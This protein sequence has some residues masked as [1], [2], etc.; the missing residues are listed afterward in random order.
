MV[1]I[2]KGSN[3]DLSMSKNY[4]GIALSSI[5]SKIFDNCIIS[6][7]CLALNSDDLQFAYKSGSS[8]T[9]CVS[10]LCET[11]DYYVHNESDVY[12]CS[13]D[14]SKAFDR[15]NILLL[16][17]KLRKRNFCPLF[18]RYLINSYCNQMMM[19]RWNGSLSSKFDVIN[20][21]KQGGALSPLLFFFFGMEEFYSYKEKTLQKRQSRETKY[22]TTTKKNIDITMYNYKLYTIARLVPNKSIQAVQLIY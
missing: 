16:F 1:P 22:N 3:K 9:L 20:G 4:R 19:V 6:A 2:P 8:T 15:V 11:I 14:A 13:I 17:R 7:E 21:V 10:V 5:F 12:M 18:L